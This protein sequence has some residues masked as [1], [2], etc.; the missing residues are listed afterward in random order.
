MSV[1]MVPKSAFKPKAFAYLRR[2]E[3]GD[4]VCITDHGRA[5]ADII[6]HHADDDQELAELRGLVLKYTGPTDPIDVVWEA[7]T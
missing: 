2:V 5:V 3:N 7:N 1:L 4:Q 6:P